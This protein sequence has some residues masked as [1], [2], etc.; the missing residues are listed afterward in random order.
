MLRQL[1]TEYP[2]ED[3]ISDHVEDAESVDSNDPIYD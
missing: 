2:A 3:E 1:R